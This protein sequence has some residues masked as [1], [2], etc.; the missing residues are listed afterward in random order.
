VSLT[1][2]LPLPPLILSH[3]GRVNP[4]LKRRAVREARAAGKAEAL[5]VLK[6]ASIQ[7]PKWLK[8]CCRTVFYYGPADKKRDPMNALEALKAY[9]D[10]IAEAGVIKDDRGLWPERPEF[11]DVERMPRVEITIEPE[12]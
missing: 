12:L 3:N 11:R 10:G 8:A 1:F 2:Q 7:P 4:F 5:R 9:I 6:D